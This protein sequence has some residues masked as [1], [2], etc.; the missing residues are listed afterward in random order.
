MSD[1][2][3]AC[4]TTW[5]VVGILA[6]LRRDRAAASLRPRGG[7]PKLGASVA[8]WAVLGVG[9]GLTTLLRIPGPPSRGA[10]GGWACCSIAARFAGIGWAVSPLASRSGCCRSADTIS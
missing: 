5:L 1:V 8:T 7:R 6:A 10:G 4:A 3:A 9:I 2:P